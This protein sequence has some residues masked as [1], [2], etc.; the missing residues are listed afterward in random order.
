M[1]LFYLIIGLFLLVAGAEIIIRGSV[2]LG[3]K[4]NISLFAIGI[5]IVAGGTSLPELAS[6][7]N[8]VINN[9]SD[10]AI[11]AVIGSNI[12]NLILVMAATTII[13]PISRITNNQINQA[14]INIGLGIFLILMSLF[15]FNYIFGIISI[16]LLIF[17]MYN[18][19]KK[20]S[21][22]LDEIKKSEHSTLISI[23]LIFIGIIFLIYGS[24]LFVSSAIKIANYFNVSE[25]VIGLSIIAFGTSL[26]ELVVGIMSALKRKVDFA[27]GN[28]LGSNIYNILGV[29]GISSFFGKFTMPEILAKQ[30]LF[31]MLTITF[32]ILGFMFFLKKIGRIYGSLGLLLYAIYMYYIFL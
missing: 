4:L 15:Y 7:I 30:D 23:I 21:L 13:L 1:D 25:A 9:H 8:A 22:N 12:A 19:V 11:G 6:S 28:I 20:G 26:P 18:Q 27:L 32:F 16:I 24:D 14:W 17:I 31:F 10:L 29:L 3:K 2:S 5:V